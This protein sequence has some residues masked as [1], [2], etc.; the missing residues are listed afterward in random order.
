[1]SKI[2]FSLTPPQPAFSDNELKQTL[3]AMEGRINTRFEQIEE[4]ISERIYDT[5]TKL[6][7]AFRGRA[8]TSGTRQATNDGP[9]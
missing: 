7:T 5:E 2:E 3:E 1:V 4:R 8:Q 6:S 9:K